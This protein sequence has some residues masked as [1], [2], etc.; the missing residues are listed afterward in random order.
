[1]RFRKTD[2]SAAFTAVARGVT[3]TDLF[4][5]EAPAL[6]LAY[7]LVRLAE[8]R[9]E[10][11]GA[12]AVERRR[13]RTDTER[14]HQAHALHRVVRVGGFVQQLRVLQLL[15][16]PL[17][18]KQHCHNLFRAR[19]CCARNVNWQEFTRDVCDSNLKQTERLVQRNGHGDLGE[20][21]ADVLAQQTEQRHVAVVRLGRRQLAAA[22]RHRA[23]ERELLVL[24]W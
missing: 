17:H 9:V 16:Q 6:V 19:S 24:R 1:M 12:R 18:N 2:C 4:S 13:V 10:G 14:R 22:A 21:L 8:Q 23:L 15:A 7:A 11:L 20:I 3:G 5:Q